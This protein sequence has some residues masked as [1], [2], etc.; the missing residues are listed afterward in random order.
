M[1]LD[2]IDHFNALDFFDS[3]LL[4][5][6][7]DKINQQL[8]LKCNYVLDR[9][10]AVLNQENNE[11]NEDFDDFYTYIFHNV[12]TVRRRNVTAFLNKK[13]NV[14]TLMAQISI[15]LDAIKIEKKG[16]GFKIKIAFLDAFGDAYFSCEG[17]DFQ[18][19]MA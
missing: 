14:D 6:N 2:F 9:I 1:K 4:I 8:T 10:S 3:E 19:V 12:K 5:F 13:N 18:R 11:N 15:N 16:E 7:Y 17:I